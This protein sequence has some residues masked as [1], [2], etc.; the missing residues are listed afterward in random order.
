MTRG[1]L[2]DAIGISLL[3]AYLKKRSMY[4]HQ[5]SELCLVYTNGQSKAL[6]Q[7]F[8]LAREGMALLGLRT[9]TESLCRE[10]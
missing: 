10:V 8:S 3:Q 4:S 5:I 9:P 6:Y 2:E 7:A 1:H